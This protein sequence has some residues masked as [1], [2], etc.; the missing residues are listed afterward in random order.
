VSVGWGLL[1]PFFYAQFSGMIRDMATQNP[2]IEQFSNFGSGNLFTI[3]GTITL[4]FQHPLAIAFVAIFAVGATSLA[5]AGERQRG[6][7]EVLLARPL[8]RNGLLLTIGAALLV[9]AAIVIAAL[10]GGMAAGTALQ[11]LGDE[12]AF[13]RLPLVF[14]N[15]VLLWAAFGA[16]GLA[17]SVTFDRSGPAIGLALGY[18]LV[19]YFLEVLGSLWTDAAWLQEYSLFHHFQ[20]AEILAGEPAIEDFLILAAAIVVPMAYALI[21]FPRRDLA[22][23]S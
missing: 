13:E 6:T 17:A 22:A 23:P 14:L 11:G 1:I 18:L 15:A 10:L 2:L 4:G 5:I 7:L 12:L 9:A 19:N 16:F 8:R 21:R 20:P 3:G